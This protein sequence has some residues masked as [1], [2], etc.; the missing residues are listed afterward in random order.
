MI[1]GL[2]QS[3]AVRS[4]GFNVVNLSKLAPAVQFLYCIMMYVVSMISFAFLF[5]LLILGVGGLSNRYLG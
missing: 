1:D 5:D 3:F 2:L 4:A